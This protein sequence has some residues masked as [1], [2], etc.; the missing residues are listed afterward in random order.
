MVELAEHSRN[1]HSLL[2]RNST[3]KIYDLELLSMR[4]IFTDPYIRALLYYGLGNIY[5]TEFKYLE[6]FAA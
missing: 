1:E 5:C 3:W 6:E 4:I 2:A